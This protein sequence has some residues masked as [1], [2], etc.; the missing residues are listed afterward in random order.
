MDVATATR[1]T[2]EVHLDLPGTFEPIWKADLSGNLGGRISIIHADV[3]DSIA[4]G[5]VA[6]EIDD[7]DHRLSL[8]AAV[9]AE[10]ISRRQLDELKAGVRSEEIERLTALKNGA[11]TLLV[12]AEKD[13]E[14]L[15]KLYA[16][17]AVPPAKWDEIVARAETARQQKIAAEAA[18]KAARSGPTAA[19]IAV[20]SAQRDSAGVAVRQARKRLADCRIISPRHST[21]VKKF[22]NEGEMVLPNEPVLRLLALDPIKFTFHVSEGQTSLIKPGQEVAVTTPGS[23]AP[24]CGKIVRVL[25]ICDE[26]T[27]RVPVEAEFPNPDHSLFPGQSGN[28]GLNLPAREGV[29]IPASAIIES[30][31]GT[32]V[33]VLEG[34]TAR[35]RK[36]RETARSKDV[37]L[38]EGVGPGSLVISRGALGLKDG[39]MV[40]VNNPVP[41]R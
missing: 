20:I 39:A 33:F 18:L 8:E 26:T 7:S 10:N 12:Q 14:R 29:M 38:V 9:A 4:S 15:G 34:M 2:L 16:E 6:W 17:E 1:G 30:E 31:S 27:R 32:S 25:P 11:D 23:P 19:Q 22:K 36:I 3:G 40:K 37:C 28:L 24:L 35:S 21:L 13:K 5:V 41:A